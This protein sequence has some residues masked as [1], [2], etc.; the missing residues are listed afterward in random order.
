LNIKECVQFRGFGAKPNIE[1]CTQVVDLGEEKTKLST[2]ES[3]EE[4]IRV[5]KEH[6]QVVEECVQVGGLG[7]NNLHL[8]HEQLG[9]LNEEDVKLLMQWN[10]IEG[11]SLKNNEEK[12]SFY[13]GCVIDK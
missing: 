1:Q 12:L 5:V 11:M 4:H 8:W 9:H 6:I 3:I 7:E 13:E 2:K 10:L